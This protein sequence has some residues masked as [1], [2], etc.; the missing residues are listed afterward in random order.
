MKMILPEFF[1]IMP[2]R[3]EF[4]RRIPRLYLQ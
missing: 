3:D 2:N 1:P 4:Y